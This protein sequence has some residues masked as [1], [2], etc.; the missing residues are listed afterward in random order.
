MNRPRQKGIQ[1]AKAVSTLAAIAAVQALRCLGRDKRTA[2]PLLQEGALNAILSTIKEVKVPYVLR[3]A[4]ATCL[5]RWS[6]IPAWQE[7]IVASDCVPIVVKMLGSKFPDEIGKAAQCLASMCRSTTVLD[8]AMKLG[9]ANAIVALLQGGQ[10]YS[11][12]A[13]GCRSSHQVPLCI[14]Q[15]SKY[16]SQSRHYGR[17]YASHL[18]PL[19]THQWSSV[20]VHSRHQPQHRGPE[21]FYR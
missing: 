4:C 5:G 12:S 17:H 9:C 18:P 10:N 6:E 19:D 8:S 7:H 14:Q 20:Q 13:S 11:S 15:S 2:V 1:S 16:S 3:G 21:C